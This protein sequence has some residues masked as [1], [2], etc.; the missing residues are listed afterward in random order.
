MK[1]TKRNRLESAGWTLGSAEEFL[2]LSPE[3]A[4]LVELRL[5]LSQALR[6]KRSRRRMSQQTLAKKLGSSQS[7]VAK[8]E[9]ADSS[10]SM[11]LLI[12]ALLAAG[13]TRRDIARA[14]Q[15]KPKTAA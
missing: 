13:A 8:M 5:S 2:E 7:R 10:V 9:A 14:I 11:D 15:R 3:E 1:H 6:E 12:R 4:A